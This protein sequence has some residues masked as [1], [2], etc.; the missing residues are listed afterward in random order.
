VYILADYQHKAAFVV[1][2]EVNLAACVAQI[3]GEVSFK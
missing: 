3:M 2:Q 1:N